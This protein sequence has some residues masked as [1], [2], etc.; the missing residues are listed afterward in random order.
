MDEIRK[1]RVINRILAVL[2]VISISAL[3]TVLYKNKNEAGRVPSGSKEKSCS[4]SAAFLGKELGLTES[5]ESSL[6][7]ICGICRGSS[8]CM[9]RELQTR[10]SEL[11]SELSKENSDTSVLNRMAADFG[12]TQSAVMKMTIRQ[13]LE[14]KKVCNQEQ[15]KKLFLLYSELFGCC[16]KGIGRKDDCSSQ[17]KKDCCSGK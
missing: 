13:Y 1:S 17:S 12:E 5:Q 3:I 16:E 11:L 14:I 10:K 7:N 9:K 2:L 6:E 4:S 8:Q 15:R